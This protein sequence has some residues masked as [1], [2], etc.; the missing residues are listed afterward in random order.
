MDYV[1]DITLDRYKKLHAECSKWAENPNSIPDDFRSDLSLWFAG[2]FRNFREFAALG[3]A[4]L[5]FK[6]SKIQAD[7]CDFMQFGGTK[8]MVQAQ[9]G[10][11]KSTLAALYI[12]WRLIQDPSTRCLIVSG[13]G[14]QA[15]DIAILIVRIIMDWSILCWLRPDVSNGDRDSTKRFDVHGSLKGIDKSASV[16]SIGITAS[17]TG[18]RADIILADDIET[19]KNSMTQPMREQLVRLTTEF[20]AICITGEIL[21]LGTPQTKDSVYKTLPHRGYNV[22]VWTGRYPTNEEL[23]RYGAGVTI[24]PCIYEALLEDPTLQE[25]GGITGKRGKPTD[26]EHINEEILQD[27]ELDYGEEG[28]T[29]QYMLDTTLSDALRT[30]IKLS[31]MVVLGVGVDEAPESVQW[32]TDPNNVYKEVLPSTSG[33]RMYWGTGKSQQY[34]KYE[35]KVMTLDPS[36]SGGDEMSYCIG[37]ATNSYIYILGMGGFLG[38]CTED[39]INKLLIRMIDAGVKD[40][41]IERNMGHGAVTALFVA[42]IEKLK[43]KCELRS[44][45]IRGLLD[46]TGLQFMAFSEALQGLGVS[47]YLVTGN[48]EKRI[49]DTISPVT[50]RHKLIISEEAIKEDWESCTRHPADRRLQYSGL[51]QLSNITYDKGSLVHDDRADAVQAVVERLQGFLAKDDEKAAEKRKEDSFQE[52]LSN[53]LGKPSWAVGGSSKKSKGRPSLCTNKYSGRNKRK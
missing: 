52:W 24:A 34:V 49:I 36:G 39:N 12:I 26:P 53:P 21:Y 33:N 46:N 48:K 29:L 25:G 19:P 14:D 42:Q 32:T 7:I 10:Q 27:K 20:A 3:M 47:D 38:G 4:K 30:K 40:L 51:Y 31:D 13:A 28:F 44:E 43:L 22:R 23:A 15:D 41:Q 5:G 35:H 11:A 18:K 1:S 6:L 8:R 17:M 2:T 9:R 37:G 45:D 50:R 16:S